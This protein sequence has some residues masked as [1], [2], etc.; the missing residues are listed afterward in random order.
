[1]AYVACALRTATDTIT[2]RNTHYFFTA[3]MVART[4]LSLTLYAQRLSCY[5]LPQHMHQTL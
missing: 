4:Q 5:G 3:K 2:V 1:M